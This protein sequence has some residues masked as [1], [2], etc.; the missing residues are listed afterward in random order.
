[1]AIKRK[2]SISTPK[3]KKWCGNE[4]FLVNLFYKSLSAMSKGQDKK[5][6]SKKAPLKTLDEKRAEKRAKKEA[7]KRGG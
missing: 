3:S 5:K 7:K 1:M 6:E 4:G 2:L